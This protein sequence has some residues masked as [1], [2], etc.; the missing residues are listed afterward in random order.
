MLELKGEGGVQEEG[1]GRSECDPSNLSDSYILNPFPSEPLIPVLPEP[2]S[3]RISK[4]YSQK[5]PCELQN[6]KKHPN[7]YSEGCCS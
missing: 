5:A 4:L 3:F 2:F 6:V 7:S 1:E